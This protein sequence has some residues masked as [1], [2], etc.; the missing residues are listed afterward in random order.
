MVQSA[1]TRATENAYKVV[2]Q[3]V[4]DYNAKQYSE[5]DKQMGTIVNVSFLAAKFPNCM[6]LAC[7]SSKAAVDMQTKGMALGLGKYLCITAK[8]YFCRCIQEDMSSDQFFKI[9]DIQGLKHSS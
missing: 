7:N 8:L 5:K 6:S 4:I 3:R 9:M 2:A 1:N